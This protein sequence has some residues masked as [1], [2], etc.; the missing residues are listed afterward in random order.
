MIIVQQQ[1]R[2][3]QPPASWRISW[4]TVEVSNNKVGG[5]GG[6]HPEKRGNKKKASEMNH[7][8]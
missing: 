6:A 8:L 2:G 5:G 3:Q 1:P 7:A 4:R